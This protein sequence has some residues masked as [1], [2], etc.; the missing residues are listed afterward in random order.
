MMDANSCPL[1]KLCGHRCGK[2]E[3]VALVIAQH[4]DDALY[5]SSA[6]PSEKDGWI[7]VKQNEWRRPATY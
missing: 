1:A 5:I 4:G 3:C 6:D 2:E 7:K